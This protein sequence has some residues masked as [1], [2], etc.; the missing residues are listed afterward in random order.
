MTEAMAGFSTASD[1][2]G[3]GTP[4]RRRGPSLGGGSKSKFSAIK[5]ESSLLAHC[6]T[7]SPVEEAAD[8][9]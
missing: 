2:P 6:G 3:F 5:S 4:R 8:V 7:D 1:S 9:P